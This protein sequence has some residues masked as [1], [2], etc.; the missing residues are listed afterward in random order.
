MIPVLI[1]FERV[2]VFVL[3]REIIKYFDEFE[4]EVCDMSEDEFAPSINYR[5]ANPEMTLFV[6]NEK[7]DSIGCYE[8]LLYKGVN[9]IGLDVQQLSLYVEENYSEEDKLLLDEGEQYVY[10]FDRIGLQV[11]AESKLGKVMSIM[12]YVK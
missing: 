4:F 6:L 1:P 3:G 5:F 10:E 2:G 12:V 8:E 9:L 7:I 11:W